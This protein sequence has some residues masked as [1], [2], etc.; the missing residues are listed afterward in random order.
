MEIPRPKH[1]QSEPVSVDPDGNLTSGPLTNDTFV[2]YNFDAR[3]RLMNVGGR[4]STS[5]T[6]NAYDALNNRIGQH[7]GTNKTAFV[8][9]PNAALPQVLMRIKNG[10]TNYYV[11]GA[12]LLYQVTETATATNTLTYHYDY[13][14]STIALTDG[15]GNVTD[16]IEYSAYGLTTYR[17]GTNDMPFLFNGKYGVQTDANGLLYMRA[18]YYNPYLCRFVSSDPAGFGGGLNILR[19]NGNPV[20]YLDPFG[21]GAVGESVLS[22]SWMPTA[23]T[24]EEQQM[25]SF[26]TDFVNFAT[27]GLANDAAIVG[28]GIANKLSG[29]SGFVRDLYGNITTPQ[30][31]MVSA[32]MLGVAFIPGADVEEAGSR[33][34]TELEEGVAKTAVSPS[35][36][37]FLGY[38]YPTKPNFGGYAQPY[39][40]TTGRF[41]TYNANPGIAYSPFAHVS[42]GFAQGYAAAASGVPLVPAV[43]NYQG[44]G[45]FA[46]KM[47]GKIAGLF[48]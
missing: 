14:G 18:R 33:V 2:T 37:D 26:L 28:N 19:F 27:L 4:S 21:L 7:Y 40:P 6:T 13:R 47:F 8:V 9:N 46:G 23:P 22:S 32:V 20:N 12:G 45:Q 41:L 5:P 3:N 39:D 1:G 48:Y 42:S 31:Q 44:W 29:G 36:P 43:S 30:E 17:A 25:Q 15:N 38:P 35:V 34:A 10:V 24:A 16:R 11:Y